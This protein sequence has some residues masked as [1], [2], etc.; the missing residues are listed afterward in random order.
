MFGFGKKKEYDVRL[1]E[2]QIQELTK[3]MSRRDRKEFEK[4]QRR[5]QA[6]REWEA[7]MMA[8]VFSDDWF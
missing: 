6:D 4:K 7:L 1:T 8:E 3:T 2:K 5:A